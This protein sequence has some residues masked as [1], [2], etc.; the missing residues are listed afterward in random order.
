MNLINSLEIMRKK[1]FALRKVK[2]FSSYGLHEYLES[3]IKC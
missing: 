2:T 1:F 3:L